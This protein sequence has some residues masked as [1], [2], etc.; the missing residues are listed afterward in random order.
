MDKNRRWMVTLSINTKNDFRKQDLEVMIAT[1][2]ENHGNSMIAVS[3]C[4]VVSLVEVKK[5]SKDN[6]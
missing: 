2:I 6:R 3:T 1:A 5:Q 4:R